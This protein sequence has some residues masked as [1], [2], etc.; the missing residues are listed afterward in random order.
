MATRNRIATAAALALLAAAAL[1]A[2]AA[3]AASA[4]ARSTSIGART[5]SGPAP[6]TL[7]LTRTVAPQHVVRTAASYDWPLKP[8]DRQH[9]VR[10]F[11]DDPRIGDGGSRAFHFGIDIAA[12][13]GTAVY[14]VEAGKVYYSSPR[15]LAIRGVTRTFGYWHIVPAVTDR[16]FVQRHQ[17]IGRIASGWGHVHFAESHGLGNYV[18]PLRPGALTPYVDG[19][20][21]TIDEIQVTAAGRRTL[22]LVVDAFDMPSP[23]VPGKWADEPVTP[24]LIR[25]RVVHAGHAGPWRTAV[26]FRW[27]KLPA[28]RFAAVYA[29]GTRQNHIGEP[30]RYRF[31][32][33]RAWRPADGSYTI[34]V[35]ASDTG[36]NSATATLPVVVADGAPLV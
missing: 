23:R 29:P 16:Q 7:Q 32:L 28:S 11:F 17:L 33:E 12:P 8:F 15:A 24:V 19:L 20:A 14:A 35:R 6:G 4:P 21:P 34:E 22:R 10:A 18:N 30:G 3:N 2:F 1:A 36:G 27:A 9:P 25:F 13:D 5:P 31:W 26:D